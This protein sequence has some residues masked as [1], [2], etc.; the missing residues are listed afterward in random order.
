MIEDNFYSVIVRLVMCF[1]LL[2][3]RFI[4]RFDEAAD[5]NGGSLTLQSMF[6]RLK[7]FIN[8]NKKDKILR[9]KFEELFIITILH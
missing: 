9:I 4:L 2:E 1:F 8:N 5:K 3:V 6:L 7:I